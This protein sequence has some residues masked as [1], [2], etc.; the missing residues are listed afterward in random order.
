MVDKLDKIGRDTV[1]DLLVAEQAWSV[2]GAQELLGLLGGSPGDLPDSNSSLVDG[3]A[4]LSELLEFS[5]AVGLQEVV[6]PDLSIAR[7]LDYYTGTVFETFLD[8]LPGFG[9][10]MSGGRYDGLIG[11]F[12]GTDIPAV[13]ISL[14]V[15][16]L[17]AGLLEL[18]L[19]E[20]GASTARVL[21]PIFSAETRVPALQLA[22]ELRAAGLPTEVPTQ[23]GRKLKKQFRYA[24]QRGIP[25]VALVGPEAAD[26]GN[27]RHKLLARRAHAVVSRAAAPEQI[28]GWLA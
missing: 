24:D 26:Q 3:R 12:R 13:G 2:D 10:V 5:A 11:L 28:K 22:N 18:G 20:Q 1:I 6:R 15:D 17:L 21:V 8:D 16:R 23:V 19:V 9:S 4:Q 14:G 27:G 25:V 7:G